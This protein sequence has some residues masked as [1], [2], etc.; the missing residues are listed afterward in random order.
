[1]LRLLGARILT[2][3]RMEKQIWNGVRKTLLYKIGIKD[4]AV[5]TISKIC[6]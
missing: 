6:M 5:N 4:I 3:G 2:I 1:M